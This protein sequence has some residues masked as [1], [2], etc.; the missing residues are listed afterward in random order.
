MPSRN[1][2]SRFAQNPTNIDISRSKFERN[3]TVKTS[4]NAGL[5]IPFY[6]DDVLPG[7]TFKVRASKVVRMSTLITPLMDNLWLDTYWFFVPNRL[8]WE[9][10][11]EFMG[12]NTQSAWLPTTEYSVPLTRSPSAT[13]Q[14]WSVGTIADYFGIPTGVPYLYVSSLPLRA[15]ALIWNEWFRDQNLQDPIPLTKGDAQSNGLNTNP[16]SSTATQM[17]QGYYLGGY[18]ACKGK[19]VKSAIITPFCIDTERRSVFQTHIKNYCPF[20]RTNSINQ[21]KHG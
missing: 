21:V 16:S 8:V 19:F 2:E 15:Y 6:Y 11:K 3:S 20:F 4:F 10:W 17:L 12:E 18:P 9:H 7:D 5:L 14:G 1:A 13:S